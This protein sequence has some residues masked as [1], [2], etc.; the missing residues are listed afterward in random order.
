MSHAALGVALVIALET[1]HVS[2]TTLSLVSC[3][4]L[5]HY[6]L[7]RVVQIPTMDI[8]LFGGSLDERL[9]GE[10][11]QAS[12]FLKTRKSRKRNVRQLA[13]AFAMTSDDQLGM[14]FRAALSA[15]PTNLP[16]EYE[17]DHADSQTIRRLKETAVQWAGQ[18]SLH[19]YRAVETQPGLTE[20]SC[21]SPVPLDEEQQA[22]QDDATA[23]PSRTKG[24]GAVDEALGGGE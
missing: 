4:R 3:Q 13:M 20:I 7:K 24:L 6:D 9:T 15:F 12:S 8:D 10:Q 1:L 16:Y 18:G 23:F 21:E 19:N 11:A 17:E 14:R 22:R 5:R 2:D